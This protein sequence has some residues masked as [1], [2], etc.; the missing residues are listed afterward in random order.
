M[1]RA[2]FDALEDTFRNPNV[3][4]RRDGVWEIDGFIVTD[5]S[6]T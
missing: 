1:S 2:R 6:W 4:T 3:W 5:R